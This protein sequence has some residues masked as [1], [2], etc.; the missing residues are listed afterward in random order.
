MHDTFYCTGFAE[1]LLHVDAV[2]K[3]NVKKNI[4]SVNKIIYL[5]APSHRIAA[6][7][8][9]SVSKYMVAFCISFLI[10]IL[11]ERLRSDLF[12]DTTF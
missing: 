2:I 1:S 8:L 6:I 9:C 12:G 3:V 11:E 7:N 4:Q 5:T 10:R